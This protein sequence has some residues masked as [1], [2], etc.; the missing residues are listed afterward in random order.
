MG[1]GCGSGVRCCNAARRST[2]RSSS[3]SSSSSVDAHSRAISV[4]ASFERAV[5]TRGERPVKV[6]PATCGLRRD[7]ANCRPRKDGR[8]GAGHLAERSAELGR[9][10]DLRPLR[11]SEI[12]KVQ[13]PVKNG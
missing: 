8:E 7:H 9:L 10:A 12:G 5:V 4:H 13:D 6:S 3:S 2:S 1:S 11:R